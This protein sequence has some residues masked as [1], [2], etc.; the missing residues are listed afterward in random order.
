MNIRSRRQI[1]RARS[2]LFTALGSLSSEGTV[3]RR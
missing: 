1:A 2:C 3:K